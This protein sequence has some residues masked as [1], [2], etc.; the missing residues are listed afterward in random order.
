MAA[1][2]DCTSSADFICVLVSAKYTRDVQNPV[3]V[4]NVDNLSIQYVAP[5]DHAT[6]KSVP[7]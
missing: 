2:A 1:N 7:S 5:F 6:Y 4:Y 3:A